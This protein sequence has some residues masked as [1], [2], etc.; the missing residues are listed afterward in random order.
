MG[1]HGQIVI[2]ACP[3]PKCGASLLGIEPMIHGQPSIMIGW[4]YTNE[5]LRDGK[6]HRLYVS[7]MWGDIASFPGLG[8]SVKDGEVLD[9]FCPFCGQEFPKVAYCDHCRA[10]IVL[11][12]AR[13]MNNGEDGFIEVCARRK[14]PQHRKERPDERRA[15]VAAKRGPGR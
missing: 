7:S 12:R 4:R 5:K 9:L 10:K 2:A 15:A 1:R 6:D 11:I 3:H 8:D 14:C 13:H